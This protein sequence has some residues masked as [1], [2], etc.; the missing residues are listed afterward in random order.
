MWFPPYNSRD[1]SGRI[2]NRRRASCLSIGGHIYGYKDRGNP[3]KTHRKSIKSK[4]TTTIGAAFGRAPQGRS[5]PLRVRLLFPL[6][7]LIFCVF[8]WDFL[9]IILILFCYYL[10]LFPN[11]EALGFQFLLPDGRLPSTW[12]SKM[13][14]SIALEPNRS[15]KVLCFSEIDFQ[16]VQPFR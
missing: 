10:I 8:S 5:A 9:D 11:S 4:E 14:N 3:K 12:T 1:Y 6:I 15:S 16:P 2:D 13:N 7:F